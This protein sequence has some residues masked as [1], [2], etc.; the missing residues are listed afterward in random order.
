MLVELLGA[1]ALAAAG[2][3]DAG[4]ASG[5]GAHE[6]LTGEPI[7]RFLRFDDDPWPTDPEAWRTPEGREFLAM[8]KLLIAQRD[9]QGA[10]FTWSPKGMVV[11]SRSW[12]HADANP[13]EG[14]FGMLWAKSWALYELLPWRGWP[15]P[16]VP[17]ELQEQATKLI[18]PRSDYEGRVWMKELTGLGIGYQ[19]QKRPLL[20]AF[21]NHPL[22]GTPIHQHGSGSGEY[23]PFDG[24]AFSVIRSTYDQALKSAA[25]LERDAQH[26]KYKGEPALP[27]SV[28]WPLIVVQKMVQD[29]VELTE[30]NFDKRVGIGEPTYASLR[31]KQKYVKEGGARF[32]IG[33]RLNP[34][35][36]L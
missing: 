19:D 11:I 16:G 18:F 13:S 4:A 27:E 25:Y 22:Y 6:L 33:H 34:E 36:R 28:I 17:D 20:Q 21:K 23:V 31:A 24:S 14:H 9:R 15:V 26:G 10:L 12:T 3:S 35:G 29:G 32:P 1:G 30:K 2:F 8:L 5:R 7:V